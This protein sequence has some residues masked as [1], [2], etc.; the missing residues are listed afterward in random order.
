MNVYSCTRI[1]SPNDLQI[2][3]AIGPSIIKSLD[4]A[5]FRVQALTRRR[6]AN[7]V[8]NTVK[9]VE[10]D[11][12]NGESLREILRGQDAVV[13]CLGDVPAAVQAQDYHQGRPPT[14]PL[15]VREPAPGRPAFY[16]DYQRHQP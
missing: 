2:T 5:G 12:S 16:I 11:Y 13:S 6:Q 7:L 14:R 3:G 1:Y 15:L 8:R 4:A 10:V 9:I